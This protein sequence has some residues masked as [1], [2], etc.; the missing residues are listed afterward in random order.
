MA[1]DN[2]LE[3]FSDIKEMR[4]VGLRP[5]E[6]EVVVQIYRAAGHDCSDGD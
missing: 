1:G 4:T 2:D 5:G 3:G 6:V